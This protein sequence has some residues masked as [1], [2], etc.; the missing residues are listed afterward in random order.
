MS[1]A[2]I[3]A[4]ATMRWRAHREARDAKGIVRKSFDAG[5]ETRA[6]IDVLRTQWGL[7]SD[8]AVI[9]KAID[10]AARRYLKR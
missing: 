4:N 9:I 1:R 3:H 7:E 8:T 5:P 10:S 6:N 2:K